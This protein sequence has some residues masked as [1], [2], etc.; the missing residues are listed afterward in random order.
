GFDL[1]G[2]RRPLDRGGGG[3]KIWGGGR[4]VG[5]GRTP[6]GL[7]GMWGASTRRACA[8]AGTLASSHDS[9]HPDR[10]EL[11]ASFWPL[12]RARVSA[13]GGHY[14]QP[15]LAARW[16]E[17]FVQITNEQAALNRNKSADLSAER[18]QEWDSQ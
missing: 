4:L 17:V 16:D 8:A 13:L 1:R 15:L 10:H 11:A 5:G 7:G 3:G 9:P 6:E 14:G 2:G 12:A 18:R